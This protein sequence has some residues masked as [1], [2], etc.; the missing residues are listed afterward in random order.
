MYMCCTIFAIKA[1]YAR[2][3]GRNGAGDL[4]ALAQKAHGRIKLSV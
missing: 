2:A 1:I 4:F 3:T